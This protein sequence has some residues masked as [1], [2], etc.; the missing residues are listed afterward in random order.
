[1]SDTQISQFLIAILFIGFCIAVIGLF[2]SDLSKNYGVAYD[3]TSLEAYN[4][5]EEI[6]NLTKEVES[7]SDIELET[8]VLDIIGAYITDAYNALKITK[9]SVNAFDRMSD[10]ALEDANLGEAGNYLRLA[11]GASILILIVL[12][13][14]LSAIMKW[15]L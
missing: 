7:G 6:N 12:G 9:K 10:Q 8:G 4:N 14:I 2:M 3:E 15:K 11:I 1:M 13:V 5:L